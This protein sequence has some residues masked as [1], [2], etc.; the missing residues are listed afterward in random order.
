[1]SA[2]EPEQAQ[3][4]HGERRMTSR[5]QRSRDN[6]AATGKSNYYRI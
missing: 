6:E 4:I 5:E 1:M 3:S 2:S